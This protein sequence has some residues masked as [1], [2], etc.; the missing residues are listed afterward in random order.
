MPL[1]NTINEKDRIPWL[2]HSSSSSQE[3]SEEEAVGKGERNE[4]DHGEEEEEEAAGMSISKWAYDLFLWEDVP[5]SCYV[6]IILNAMFYALVK[7]KVPLP[8]LLSQFSIMSIAVSFAFGSG[9]TLICR[10]LLGNDKM[11]NPIDVLANLVEVP[12]EWIAKTTKLAGQAVIECAE[13]IKNVVLY[14]NPEKSLKAGCA[15]LAVGLLSQRYSAT[16]LA[17]LSL[18]FCFVW[19]PVYKYQRETVDKCYDGSMEFAAMQAKLLK[20]DSSKFIKK[21]LQT[22]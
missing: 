21:Y 12:R 13:F 16:A 8:V 20:E 3:I 11:V 22:K 2:R 6:F 15:F 10:H 1:N 14:K 19:F 18:N 7:L 4:S 17:W 5:T 9:P